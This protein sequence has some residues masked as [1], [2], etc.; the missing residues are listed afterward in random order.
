MDAHDRLRDALGGVGCTA[1]GAAVDADRI[2]VLA[3][4]D[5]LVFIEVRCG[6][7]GS[8]TLGLVVL[9]L[10]DDGA[11]NA[12]LDVAL[13]GEWGPGDEARLASSAPLDATDVE[14]MHAFLAGYRGDLRSLIEPPANGR[15]LGTSS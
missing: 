13:P 7:C 5:D 11:T 4:R 10:D 6:S 2:L 8:E 9:G 1:C 14:R 12:S 15:G 3:E